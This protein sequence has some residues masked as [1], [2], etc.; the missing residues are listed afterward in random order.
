MSNDISMLKVRVD[1]LGRVTIPVKVRRM[2]NIEFEDYVYMSTDGTTIKIFK[3]DKNELTNRI[4]YIEEVAG[5]SEDITVSEYRQLCEI[6]NKLKIEA[7]R[8]DE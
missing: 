5:D 7:G 1:A 4:K 3:K 8:E 6:M 2:L